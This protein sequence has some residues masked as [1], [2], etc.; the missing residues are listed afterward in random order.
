MIKMNL[1]KAVFVLLSVLI[2]V[3]V[4]AQYDYDEYLYIPEYYTEAVPEAALEDEAHQY[5]YAEVAIPYTISNNRFY[6]ES[7]RLTRL[8]HEAF[9]FGDYDASAGFAQEAIRYALLSDEFVSTQLINEA[10]RLL[11]WAN[12]NNVAA[13]FPGPYTVGRNY[14][15]ASVEAHEEDNWGES[16][17]LAISSISILTALEVDRPVTA[18]RPPLPAQYTVRT[19]AIHRDSLWTIAGYPWVFNDP[20]R[21]PVL[22]EANRAR[23]PDPNN[24][25]LIEPGFVLDIPSLTGEFRQ[26]MWDPNLTYERFSR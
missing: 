11:V 12:A 7:V 15:E 3:P 1:R 6:R 13:R 17:P 22:F 24:P 26:G 21:W 2:V 5:E 10:N 18:A 25:H 9:E 14:Y 19:W 8:A 23:M 4:F 16:I 20:F